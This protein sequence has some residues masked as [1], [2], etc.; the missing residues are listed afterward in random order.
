MTMVKSSFRVTLRRRATAAGRSR[1]RVHRSRIRPGFRTRA[2]L[3]LAIIGAVV[4]ADHVHT[5][6]RTSWDRSPTNWRPLGGPDASAWLVDLDDGHAVVKVVAVTARRQFEAGLAA[7]EWLAGA[8]MATGAPVRAAN[9][10]LSV[11]AGPVAVAL[12][13]YVPGRPLDG[14]NAVDQQWWGDALGAAHRALTGFTHA[15]LTRLRRV[16]PDAPHLAVEAWVRPAVAEAVD[17]VARLSVTDQL[18]YGVLHGDPAPKSFRLDVDTGRTGLLEWGAAATGPL[19]YDVA[20]AVM[21][22]GGPD[23]AAELVDGYL[24]AGPVPRDELD[25]ALHPM[26]RFRYAV[27]ADHFA[28]LIWAGDQAAIDVN[29]DRLHRTRDHLAGGA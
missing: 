25:T 24:S 7:A 15:A 8:G 21:Y 1:K 16:R 5:A 9:G 11:T 2:A 26:L 28:R 12:L 4:H 6:V 27:Q 20:S 29:R 3:T 19:V 18:S 23:E 13:H 17:G 14:A 22:A 10:A